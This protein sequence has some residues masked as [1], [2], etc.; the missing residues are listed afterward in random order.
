MARLTTLFGVAIAALASCQRFHPEAPDPRGLA[1]ELANVDACIHGGGSWSLDARQ[2]VSGADA[3][4]AAA[5][6]WRD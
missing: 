6:T 2:C 4:A 5:S 3:R 1:E